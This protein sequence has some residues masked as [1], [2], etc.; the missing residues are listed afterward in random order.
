MKTMLRALPAA[1]AALL[2]LAP[3][4][5]AQDT[6]EQVVSRYFDTFRTG[7]YAG[8]VALM[9][10]QA[11]EEVRETMQGLVALA[12]TRDSTFQATFGVSSEAEF[13]RLGAAQLFERMLRAQL[14]NPD[15]REVLSTART[16]VLGHVMEG[17][18]LAHVVYRMRMSVGAMDVDQVQVAP[19]KRSDGQWRVMLTGSLAGMMNAVPR[20][21]RTPE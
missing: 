11:L 20:A 9:H 3:G 16:T 6:P 5:G 19:V 13:N 15:M 4:L 17:D 2:A 1:A 10:P 21:G 18:T 8:N 7:D 12:G 14:E